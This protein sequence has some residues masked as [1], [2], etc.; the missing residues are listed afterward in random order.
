MRMYV[1]C[2]DAGFLD[3]ITVFWCV[4]CPCL[5][6]P[7]L[8]LFFFLIQ[9]TILL[10]LLFLDQALTFRPVTAW[11]QYA[12]VFVPRGQKCTAILQAHTFPI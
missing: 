7:R 4:S 9:I 1:R 11:F 6:P 5:P 12:L 8:S 2:K 10:T 3:N